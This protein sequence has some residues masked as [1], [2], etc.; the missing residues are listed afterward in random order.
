MHQVESQDYVDERANDQSEFD[1]HAGQMQTED[2][3]GN[4]INQKKDSDRPPDILKPSDNGDSQIKVDN[5][6]SAKH[7]P[8]KES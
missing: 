5:G 3:N 2:L 1:L 7:P 6:S 4:S 8:K